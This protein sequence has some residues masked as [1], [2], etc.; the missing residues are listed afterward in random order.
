CGECGGGRRREAGQ[1][2]PGADQ[3]A[4]QD[5]AGR[6]AQQRGGRRRGHG[7]GRLIVPPGRRRRYLTACHRRRAGG[8][9][10]LTG[11]PA[12]RRAS[13]T[14]AMRSSPKWKTLAASTASAPASI[15]GAKWAGSPAPPLAMIGTVT[16]ART[17][18]I[19]SRSNPVLVPSP[20]IELTKIS[21]TPSPTA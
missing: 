2:H 4:G 16:A 1:V 11:C 19:S 3:R 20:S 18:R 8:G 15:A 12:A 14:S 17:A 6:A 13:F 9:G 10:Y 21:P 5:R 7:R